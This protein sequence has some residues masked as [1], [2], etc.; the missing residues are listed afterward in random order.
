MTKQA[1]KLAKI[2]RAAGCEIEDNGSHIKVWHPKGHAHGC[3]TWSSTPQN[4]DDDVND[5]RRRMEKEGWIP[6][7]ANVKSARSWKAKQGW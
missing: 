3:H 4:A 7:Q 2:A 1:K 5:C 6:K